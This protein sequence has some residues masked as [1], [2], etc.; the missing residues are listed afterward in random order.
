MYP[1]LLGSEQCL[2]TRLASPFDASCLLR[3][4]RVSARIT[5]HNG[6]ARIADFRDDTTCFPELREKFAHLHALGDR[7]PS[8]P[9][10]L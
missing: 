7:N 2:K 4:V 3:E 10:P 5:L 9:K 8:R 6:A 1:T